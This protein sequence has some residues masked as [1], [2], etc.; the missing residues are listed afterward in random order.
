M[1]CHVVTLKGISN[2]KGPRTGNKRKSGAHDSQKG[3]SKGKNDISI[4]DKNLGIRSG[5]P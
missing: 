2:L 1:K 3:G 5:N 4:E